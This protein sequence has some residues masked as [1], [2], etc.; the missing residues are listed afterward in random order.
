M[1]TIR[2][3]ALARLAALALAPAAI[4]APIQITGGHVTASSSGPGTP[5]VMTTPTQNFQHTQS[6]ATSRSHNTTTYDF[7]HTQDTSTLRILLD[8]GRGAITNDHATSHGAVLITVAEPTPYLV[9]GDYR[10]NGH[11]H[12]N[13]IA[14]VEHAGPPIT[15]PYLESSASQATD[16]AH[17]LDDSGD[18]VLGSRSGI[19]AP[20]QY[21]LGWFVIIRASGA[22]TTGTSAS[23][24]GEITFH[25]GDAVS[26]IPLPQSA[27]LA[28][29]GLALLAVRRR[30]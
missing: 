27:P 30:R 2:S 7:S 29:A 18:T 11:R 24:L 6:S 5:T 26:I 22:G 12:S 13:L 10:L 4:A 20:G 17:D 25:F 19:L 3:A 8:H 16:A 23:A 9:T 14:Y 21:T 15:Y 1:T 28:A